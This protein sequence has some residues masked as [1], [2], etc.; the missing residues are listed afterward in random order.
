MKT[1]KAKEGS[2]TVAIEKRTAKIPSVVYLTAG[3]TAL[4]ASVCLMCR[5]QK[6]AGLLVGQWTAPLLIMGLYNKIVKTEG[7]D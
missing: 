7:H 4:T 6:A 1:D 3:M 5:G 2:A